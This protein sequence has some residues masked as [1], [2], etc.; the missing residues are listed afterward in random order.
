MI[1]NCGRVFCS[2]GMLGW[3]V[4]ILIAWVFVNWTAAYLALFKAELLAA[5]MLVL[6]RSITKRKVRQG[7]KDNYRYGDRGAT[8]LSNPCT[9]NGMTESVEAKQSVK[10]RCSLACLIQ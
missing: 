7:S 8:V 6:Q 2:R 10:L 1:A 4:L 3:I 9:N 5:L